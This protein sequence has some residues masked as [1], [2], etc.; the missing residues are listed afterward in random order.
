MLRARKLVAGPSSARPLISGALA[1][2]VLVLGSLVTEAAVPA[3]PA[4]A[5]A[6]S[7]STDAS[8]LYNAAVA[9]THAWSVHYASASTQ[10]AK[11]LLASGDAGPASGTQMVT[12]GAGTISIVVIGGISYVKGN[13]GGLQTLVGMSASQAGQTANQWIEFSTTSADFA[14]VVAGV[15]SSDVAKELALKAP[16]SLGHSR[17]LDGTAVDAIKG[18]QTFGKTT[19]HVVLYVRAHGSHVPIEEDSVDAQGAR[20]GAEHVTYSKWGEIVRPRAPKAAISIG[21][22]SSV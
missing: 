19:D 18:T 12:M 1:L 8:A 5:A 13:A 17:T 6:A 11:T 20:T 10:S 16:L 7:S 9:T 4:A 2:G 3:G 22:I 21:P 14:Q 15:R